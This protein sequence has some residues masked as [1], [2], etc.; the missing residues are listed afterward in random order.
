[1]VDCESKPVRPHA[2]LAAKAKQ[3]TEEIVGKAGQGEIHEM[4]ADHCDSA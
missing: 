1:M 4:D 2:A 3:R